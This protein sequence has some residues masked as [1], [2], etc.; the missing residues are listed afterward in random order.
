[1]ATVPNVAVSTVL[2]LLRSAL[3]GIG[4]AMGFANASSIALTP[5]FPSASDHSAGLPM[6]CAPQPLLPLAPLNLGISERRSIAGTP[7]SG[8]NASS[9]S[10]SSR[11]GKS[12]L[13]QIVH[14]RGLF[15]HHLDNVADRLDAAISDARAASARPDGDSGGSIVRPISG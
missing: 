5:I 6:K 8:V 11:D 14:C 9:T 4:L 12:S 10:T 15:D 2:G 1:M 3:L 13:S 7:V